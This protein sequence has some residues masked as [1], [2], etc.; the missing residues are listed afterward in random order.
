MIKC[1]HYRSLTQVTILMLTMALMLGCDG[2]SSNTSKKNIN[3]ITDYQASNGGT[4]IDAMT[5]EPSGLI[6]MI[7]GESAASAIAGNIFNSL[8]KYDK[9]LELTGE[10]AKSWEIS[11]DQKTIT[12]H[13]KPNL[14]WADNTA[15]TSDDVLFTWLR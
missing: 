9:N 12:F 8:L 14:K 4:L 1:L 13:L 10:L 7:A 3:Y 11:P 15:L 6:A 2:S 5:G